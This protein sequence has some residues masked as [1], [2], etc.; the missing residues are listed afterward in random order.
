MNCVRNGSVNSRTQK[1]TGDASSVWK[2]VGQAGVLLAGGAGTD[3]WSW[4][5]GGSRRRRA[6]QMCSKRHK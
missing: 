1:G 2:V 3:T 5:E 4:T 6:E